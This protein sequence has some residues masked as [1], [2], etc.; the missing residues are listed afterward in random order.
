MCFNQHESAQKVGEE[1]RPCL[2]LVKENR[3]GSNPVPHP[4]LIDEN[5]VAWDKAARRDVSPAST[6]LSSISI[7]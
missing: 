2:E 6:L 4:G 7:A 1:E 5:L 3:R